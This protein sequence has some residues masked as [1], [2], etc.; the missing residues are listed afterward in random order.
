[1]SRTAKKKRRRTRVL[2]P[3]DSLKSITRRERIAAR[4]G[5]AAPAAGRAWFAAKRPV[6]RF[7]LVLGGLMAVFNAFFYLWLV[8]GDLLDTYLELVAGLSA[9]ALRVLGDEATASDGAI[10]SPRYSLSIR[11]GCDAIQV[12]AFFAFAVLAS[13]VSVPLW[14]RTI[15]L[16][17]GV[18]LLLGLN[19]VRIVSLFYTGIYFPSAF[20]VMHVEVWQPAFIFLAL[21]LWIMWVWRVTR[22]ATREADVAV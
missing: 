19:L 3:R 14:R 10:S 21:F 1:M 8:P 17:V 11:H 5:T 18:V 16:G 20:E 22:T 15:A 6:L 9:G 12:A 7:V 13:P 4:R 2:A